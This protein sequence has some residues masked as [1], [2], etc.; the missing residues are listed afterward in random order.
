MATYVISQGIQ[1]PEGA[2]GATG[3]SGPAGGS[4][5]PVTNGY[6]FAS[7]ERISAKAQP[8]NPVATY[9]TNVWD[10][11]EIREPGAAIYDPVTGLWILAYT[12]EYVDGS[13]TTVGLALWSEDGVGWDPHPQNPI[14]P[15]ES[16]VEYGQPV[17]FDDPYV[18]KTV[19]GEVWRDTDGRAHIYAEEKDGTTHHGIGLWKS[20]VD[21][22]SDWT[23]AGRVLD[24]GAPG[25][26]DATD[27]TSPCVIHDGTRLIMLFEGRNI[28]ESQLGMT[29][30]AVSTDEGASWTP[31]DTNPII[32][33]GDPGTWNDVSV[34]IDDIIKVGGEWIALVH[35]LATEGGAYTV[36]RY[37]TTDDPIDWNPGSFTE[38]VGNPYDT[39]TNTM[40][41][42]GN[43]P[44][45]GVCI[46]QLE[47]NPGVGE[48]LERVYITPTVGATDAF[49]SSSLQGQIN[50][51]DGRVDDNDTDI[52]MH[53]L[54]IAAATQ[55]A[56]AAAR[57]SRIAAFTS[58]ILFTE[59]GARRA[60]ISSAIA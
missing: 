4:T 55:D 37:R 51:L 5:V 18:A 27:R 26:W 54:T 52:A 45:Q 49:D 23:Y 16:F 8:V 41:C 14:L 6:G 15:L 48:S 42:W 40:M 59:P 1:G 10:T 22:L 13:A 35:G 56:S 2:Q 32:L 33:L 38:C 57:P 19:N 25:S 17:N 9:D 29:G 44:T 11:N 60:S 30:Q 50:T 28:P 21:S 58:E 31:H 20:G 36:G 3:P 39:A 7:K 24:K 12:G 34:V 47:A 46:R 53:D 43:D